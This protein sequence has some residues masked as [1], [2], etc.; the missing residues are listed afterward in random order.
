MRQHMAASPDMQIADVRDDHKPS[1]PSP[2]YFTVK[3]SLTLIVKHGTREQTLP[4]LKQ[5]L[6]VDAS[7]RVTAS[8]NDC[9][10][11]GHGT[12]IEIRN[13]ERARTGSNRINLNVVIEAG[14]EV[15]GA[16][17][18]I[19]RAYLERSAVSRF[20]DAD[21][22]RRQRIALRI[23]R[24]QRYRRRRKDAPFRGELHLF[25]ARNSLTV[26]PNPWRTGAINHESAVRRGTQGEDDHVAR[27]GI[28]HTDSGI[29]EL[30]EIYFTVRPGKNV[31]IYSD[32]RHRNRRKARRRSNW[33][34]INRARHPRV[35]IGRVE[36][37]V[38][39]LDDTLRIHAV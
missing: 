30:V 7:L 25:D 3:P 29:S 23:L 10:R 1:V 33:C 37:P 38:V 18:R 34:N 13:R 8:T 4:D 9:D 11:N 2:D 35:R 32:R 27:R 39:A 31:R 15:C 19:Q 26:A 6:V 5:R 24:V 16:D 21:E 14:N 22:S 20:T 12:R 28:V 36:F 17:R